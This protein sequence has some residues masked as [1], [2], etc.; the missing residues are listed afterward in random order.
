[1]LKQQYI[2]I[3]QRSSLGAWCALSKPAAMQTISNDRF[4]G[5]MEKVY[6]IKRPGCMQT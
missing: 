3:H 6:S 1:M 5:R 4:N 2:A